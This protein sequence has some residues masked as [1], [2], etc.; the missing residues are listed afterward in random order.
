[1]PFL[2]FQKARS[3]VRKVGLKSTKKWEKWRKSGGR[4]FNI[5]SHPDEVYR[6]HGW[7]SYPDFMGYKAKQAAKKGQ[8]LPFK[9]A[10]SIVWKVGLKGDKEWKEWRK[11]G[12]RPTNIPSHPGKAYRDAGWNEW[13]EQAILEPNNITGYQNLETINNFFT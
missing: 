2:S 12:K 6:D 11:S 10:R 5:P 8:M 4:P 7:V 13:N 9:K 1:M 3:V